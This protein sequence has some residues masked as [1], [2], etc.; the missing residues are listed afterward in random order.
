[1]SARA[2]LAGSVVFAATM[3]FFE[4]AVVV[5]LRRLWE[6]GQIDVATATLS[7]RLLLT[8]VLREVASLGMIASVAYLA[9]RR[10]VERFAHAAVIFG[11]WDLLYYIYLRLLIG[12]PTSL[13]DW[14]ILFLIPKTWVG[15]V[16][17]PILVSAALMCAGAYMALREGSSRPVTV[18]PPAWMAGIVGGVLV[19]GSF[20]MPEVPRSP[21]DRPG[22]FSWA[23]FLTGL[24]IACAGFAHIVRASARH[25][26][27]AQA[28][29]PQVSN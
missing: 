8:E 26:V 15:P 14:D 2:R 19:I 4:A 11:T 27:P 20:L 3:G 12:W 5:Y 22:G 18:Q 29:P 25:E 6:L 23:I 17:A 10:S 13:C 9:G 21:T 7:N 16:L 1:M 24:G 28:I